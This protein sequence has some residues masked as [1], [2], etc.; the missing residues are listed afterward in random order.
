MISDK[1][2]SRIKKCLELSSSS[3]AYEAAVALKRAKKLMKKYGLSDDDITLLTVGK[4]ESNTVVPEALPV[5]LSQ[6]ISRFQ[7]FTTAAPCKKEKVT[8]ILFYISAL[9]LKL[10]LQLTLLMSYI[11]N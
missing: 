10:S 6:L 8:L 11:D 4:T 5:Y 3:N 7:I 1:Y 2:M 9:V